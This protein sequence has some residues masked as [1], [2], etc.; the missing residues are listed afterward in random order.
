VLD[1]VEPKQL[2]LKN[3]AMKKTMRFL[4][5]TAL[6]MVGA[7]MTGCSSDDDEVIDKKV[8]TLT[9]TIG[10]ED[11]PALTRALTAG[12]VKTFGKGDKLA[13]VYTNTN[14]EKKVAESDALD[15]D[16]D[17]K[18]FAKFTFT[19]ENPKRIGEVTYVYPAAMADANETG[20]VKY[21]RLNSQN[22][23]FSKLASDFD[24]CT[25]TANWDGSNLPGGTLTNQLAILAINDLKYGSDVITST[26]NTLTI[27]GT[28]VNRTPAAG[29]IYVAIQPASGT[30]SVTASSVSYDY[31]KSLSDKNYQ[32]GHIYPVTWTMT[33]R[34]AK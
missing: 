7:V 26:I 18:N 34:T 29:P 12:G 20:Y 32:A 16:Y 23:T 13:V 11:S 1:T 6:A 22:G 9:T 4:Y 24:L 30:I 25:L 21:S 15:D 17:G 5:M 28:T 19:L 10:F 2:E 31:S 27:N 14:D 33:T 8:V 3:K